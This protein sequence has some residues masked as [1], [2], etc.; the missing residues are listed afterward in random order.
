MDTKTLGYTARLVRLFRITGLLVPGVL[1]LYGVF[2]QR[3]YIQS[4]HVVDSI[5]LPAFAFWWLYVGIVQFIAPS[6]TKLDSLLRLVVYHLLVGSYLVFV[7]GVSSPFIGCWLLLMLASYI[8]SPQKGLQ[9]S[10]FSFILVIIVDILLWY[11]ID[12]SVITYDSI[13]LAIILMI[14]F[15]TLNISRAQEVDKDE[16]IRSKTQEIL[17]R[18]RVITIVN[19]MTDAVISTDKDGVIQIYNAASMNLLDTNDNLTNRHIDSLLTLVDEDNKNISILKELKKTKSVIKR[20]DLNYIFPDN[21]KI[22]LDITYSPIRSSYSRSKKAETHDGY[23]LIMRDITKQK[24]LEEEKDEFISVVS[25]ELRTPVTIAEGTLS[26]SMIMLGHPDTTNDMLKD[27][28]NMAHD[29][30]LFLA[31]MINDLSALS[32]AERGVADEVEEIN[33]EDLSHKLL[34]KYSKEAKEKGLTLDL[35]LEPNT[36]N[37]YASRLYLEESLQNFITNAIK[38]TKEGGVTIIVKKKN[39]HI[40]FAIKDTGIGISK[41][42]QAKIFQKFYRSEDYRTRETGGTGLG[43]YVASKLADKLGAKIEVESRLNFGSTF[44]LIIPVNNPEVAPEPTENTTN[45][46]TEMPKPNK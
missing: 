3:G 40:S 16:L 28:I 7:S 10:V 1:I 41:S 30:I 31:S 32:R 22:S 9:V 24:S 37:V 36:G 2:I 20:D 39:S 46:P 25:H 4:N 34:D 21:E 8:H 17:Q 14:G 11:R 33:I 45:K 6:K 18:D 15:V 27:S 13:A 5:S 35:E 29:Q 42:D 38:Y 23:I 43:L 19:N 26:N 12:T 44:T